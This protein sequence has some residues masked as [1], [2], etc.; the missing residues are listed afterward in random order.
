[1]VFWVAVVMATVNLV[2]CTIMWIKQDLR[3]QFLLALIYFIGF[4]PVFALLRFRFKKAV[5]LLPC[6]VFFSQ[7]LLIVI[8]AYVVKDA[9]K[10][11]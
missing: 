7:S 1:M 3:F 9:L 6:L 11:D 10:Q 2:W 5:R 8:D 4:G